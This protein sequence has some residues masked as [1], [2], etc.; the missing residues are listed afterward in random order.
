[1]P[2]IKTDPAKQKSLRQMTMMFFFIFI[3]CSI[4]WLNVQH[5]YYNR[6]KE[7]SEL[8]AKQTAYRFE[9]DM[10][11]RLIMVY[12]VKSIME[13]GLIDNQNSFN[14][15]ISPLL[16]NTPDIVN[17]LFVDQDM[18]VRWIARGN[19]DAV[20]HFVRDNN[21]FIFDIPQQRDLMN[22][23]FTEHKTVISQPLQSKH[24]SNI[25]IIYSPV[26]I[27]NK[28]EG[29]LVS[30]IRMNV[31]LR[32]L[33][34]RSILQSNT[35]RLI[36]R[37]NQSIIFSNA[38]SEILSNFIDAPVSIADHAFV[39]QMSVFNEHDLMISRILVLISTFV[40]A[41]LMTI[42]GYTI[43]AAIQKMNKKN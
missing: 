11:L 18:T 19:H 7:K 35:V 37:D 15:F 34:N 6:E 32:Q 1:M 29:Y 8:I 14:D 23:A 26:F 3:L 2:I 33:L 39:L 12:M 42:I 27:D 41:A 22:Q 4:A 31:M 25:M 40:T 43:M 20:N 30:M 38:R 5:D 21:T 9:Q 16:N 13:N 24:E 17:M 36:D 28:F 10:N